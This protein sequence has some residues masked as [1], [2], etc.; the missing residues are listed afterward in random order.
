MGDALERVFRPVEVDQ[1]ASLALVRGAGFTKE[2][3]ARRYLKIGGRWQDH[4][5][6]ALLAEDPRWRAPRGTRRGA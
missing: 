1:A 3:L 4:E 5:M 2:G 6:W